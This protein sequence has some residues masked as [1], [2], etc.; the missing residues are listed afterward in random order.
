MPEKICPVCSNHAPFRLR[1]DKTDYHQCSSCR[2]LFSAPIDQD[3]MVGGEHEVGRNE[4]QNHL[5]IRRIEEMI[6]GSKKEKAQILDFGCGNGY[7]IKDLKNAGFPNVSGYDAFNPEFSRLPD[8]NTFHIVTMVE[9]CEHISYPFVEFDLI[10]RSLLPGSVLMIETS[11]VDVAAEENIP[12]EDFF[13]I[14]PEKGH[15]SIHSHHSLDLLMVFKGF[16][17]VQHINRHVR[18]FKKVKE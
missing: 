7:L 4:T 5:R 12:L 11:F 6:L 13:Y 18:L 16:I 9:V 14:S 17:P 3:N 1:K 8:K 2:F 15:S 10:R